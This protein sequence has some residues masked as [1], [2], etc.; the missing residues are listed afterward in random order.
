MRVASADPAVARAQVAR[1]SR[2]AA[3]RN[4]A[5]S[6]LRAAIQDAYAAGVPY[7]E[8]ARELGV[9]RQ[10]VRQFANPAPRVSRPADDIAV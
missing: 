2:A 1:V 5:D 6:V 10:A 4:N 3:A 8:L 9:T 7:A